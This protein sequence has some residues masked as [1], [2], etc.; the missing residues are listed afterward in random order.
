MKITYDKV[1]R[2]G[3]MMAVYLKRGEEKACIV[4]TSG[5][6]KEGILAAFNKR[7]MEIINF[8][9]VQFQKEAAAWLRP[10]LESNEFKEKIFEARKQ[11]RIDRKEKLEKL[12]KEE[13]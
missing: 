12:A 13:K 11:Y 5:K 7:C 4:L 2:R 9:Q 8:S 10:R 3:K 1:V 6:V